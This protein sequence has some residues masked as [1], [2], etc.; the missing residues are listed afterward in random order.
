MGRNIYHLNGCREDTARVRV[1]AT[2]HQQVCGCVTRRAVIPT[3]TA[4][5]VSIVTSITVIPISS[6]YMP[7]VTIE[8]TTTTTA[9]INVKC[10]YTYTLPS[11]Y[12]FPIYLNSTVAGH[13]IRSNY[14]NILE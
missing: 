4:I 5:L 10:K 9:T 12:Q 13:K 1:C 6:C 3:T 14:I 2:L 8:T 11:Q 7:S